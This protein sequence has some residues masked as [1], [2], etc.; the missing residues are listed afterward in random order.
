MYVLPD[1]LKDTLKKY[2]GQLVDEAALLKLLRKEKNF[3]SVGDKVTYTVLK[4]GFN[5]LLCIVD[6]LLERKPY[7]LEMKAYIQGFEAIHLTIKNPP[8]T[9]TDELWDAIKAV[10]QNPKTGPVCIEIDGEEDLASL[11]AIYL[12]PPGVT[13]I[14]GLPNKGVVVVKAT[15]AHK[16]KVQEVLDRM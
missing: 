8:G 5:P 15:T 13:V 3:V 12:A 6:F 16:Q 2:I 11:A 10:Y 9:I 7:P 4:H 14:Y 1:D